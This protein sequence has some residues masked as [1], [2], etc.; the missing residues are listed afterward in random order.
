VT[1]IPL[2]IAEPTGRYRRSLRR[3]RSMC[4]DE[5]RCPVSGYHD[6]SVVIGDVGETEA[7]AHG[8]NW[9]H[10]DPRWPKACACGYEFAT[11]DCGQPGCPVED[12]WQR[13]DCLIYRLPDGTEFI[14]W[15]SAK[16]VPPGT[17]IRLPWYDGRGQGGEAWQVW[18]P[19]GGTWIT[20]QA[21]SG[22]GYWTVT[23]TPPNI[24]ASPSIWHNAPTGW[25]GFIRNGELIP[26]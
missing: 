12:Q 15:G 25:H 21:A 18:L 5:P 8:D 2:R 17:M 1:G 22:G 7:D 13:N 19:D 6:A 16:N 20:T 24:T 23:G 14:N 9:P 3:Y 11:C 4:E 26:A 10:D